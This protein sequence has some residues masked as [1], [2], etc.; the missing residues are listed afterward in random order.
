ME[1]NLTF[2]KSESSEEWRER[3]SSTPPKEMVSRDEDLFYILKIQNKISA[4]F[5]NSENPSSPLH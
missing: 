2:V 5:S 1:V 3:I 4:C